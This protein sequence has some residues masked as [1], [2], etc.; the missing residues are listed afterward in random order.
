MEKACSRPLDRG[1]S[2][3]LSVVAWILLFKNGGRPF[4]ADRVNSLAGF[5][6]GSQGQS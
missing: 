1:D 6:A 5:V 2:S 4:A 3:G